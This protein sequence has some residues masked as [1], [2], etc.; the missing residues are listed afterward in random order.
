[1][2]SILEIILAIII[3]TLSIVM[4]IYY[5]RQRKKDLKQKNEPLNDSQI[6]EYIT[7]INNKSRDKQKSK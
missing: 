1:M 2:V 6:R 7:K 5:S 3:V 4:P